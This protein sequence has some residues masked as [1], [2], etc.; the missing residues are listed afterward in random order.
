MAGF[1]RIITILGITLLLIGI[2]ISIVARIFPNLTNLPGNFSYEGDGFQ[3]WLPLTTM[4]VFSILGT[5]LLN[6][7]L[8]FFK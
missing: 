3:I 7:V 8:R 6:I 2:L 5:I 4:L 1:G